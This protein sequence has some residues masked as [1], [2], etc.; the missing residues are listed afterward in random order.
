M[1]KPK[2][3]FCGKNAA[4]RYCPSLDQL[5]CPVCCGTNRLRDISCQEDC[6]YLDHEEYQQEKC[7]Q[8]ELNAILTEVP[9]SQHDDIFKNERAASI[10]Y[11]FE[12]F[13]ADCYIKGDFNLRD[14]KVKNALTNLYFLKFKGEHI[15]TDDFMTVL[16]E[17]YDQISGEYDSRD[18]IGKVILR[19]IISIKNMTGGQ[20]GAYG[21]LNYLKNNIHPSSLNETNEPVF[22]FKD[23]RIKEYD[24]LL[25]DLNK[26]DL[27]L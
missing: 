15:K 14:Q 26:S 22:E 17:L 3:S 24:E 11:Q 2:C 6:R 20:F 1:A 21:Y 5:I 7:K 27:D 23:G 19:M 4:K 12:T 8:K 16:I 13:F 25:K 9:H 18:L 10:A